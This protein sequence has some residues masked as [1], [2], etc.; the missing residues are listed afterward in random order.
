[1]EEKKED[2]VFVEGVIIDT[3]DIQDGILVDITSNYSIE[4]ELRCRLL[5][6]AFTM[7]LVITAFCIDKYIIEFI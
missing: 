7:V 3:V 5:C 1:M 4:N 6:C 2:D